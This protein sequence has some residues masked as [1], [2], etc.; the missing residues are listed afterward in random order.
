MLQMMR[1]QEQGWQLD[2]PLLFVELG[3]RAILF[4]EEF[5]R[6]VLLNWTSGKSE[7]VEDA[8]ANKLSAAAAWIDPRCARLCGS[9]SLRLP[10]WV[11]Q[12]NS[13]ER[14]DDFGLP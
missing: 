6:K 7:R 2:M 9:V 3:L 8:G 13:H 12:A 10:V 5:E 14:H 4:V 11:L 1:T